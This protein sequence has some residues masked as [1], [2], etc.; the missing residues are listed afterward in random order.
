MHLAWVLVVLVVV[1]IAVAVVVPRLH[2]SSNTTSRASARIALAIPV[3]LWMSGGEFDLT[4][5]DISRGGICL[6]GDVRTSA[7][8]PVRLQFALPGSAPL[9][10]HGVVRW[11]QRGR[12]GVLF[13]LQDR[14]RIAV[15]DW[16]AAHTAEHITPDV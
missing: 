14:R 3:R 8:Q 4:T 12:L 6:L 2:K 13:D 10:L 7:G 11:A 16:I 5:V 15:G 9:V 1:L